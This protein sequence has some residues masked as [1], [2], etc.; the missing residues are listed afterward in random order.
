MA[1]QG[2]RT[3]TEPR[4]Q[5]DS[6]SLSACDQRIWVSTGRLY[7]CGTGKRKE[8][9]V[10]DTHTATQR[11]QL[12]AQLQERIDFLVGYGAELAHYRDVA[13]PMWIE[14]NS[15]ELARNRARLQRLRLGTTSG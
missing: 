5:A 1:T 12:E 11:R 13:F 4:L 9:Q 7:G 10:S 6:P 8:T 3:W 14:E 15:R 2:P